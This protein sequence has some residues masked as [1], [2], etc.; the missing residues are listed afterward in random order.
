MD[1][2]D[3]PRPK[4]S[5]PGMSRGLAPGHVAFGHDR[6]IEVPFGH[7]CQDVFAGALAG[8]SELR[9]IR[10]DHGDFKPGESK[11]L[12]VDARE[13]DLDDRRGRL[14]EQVEDPRRRARSKRRWQPCHETY[15]GRMARKRTGRFL[16]VPYDWR[17]PTL[18]RVRS[19]WWNRNDRRVFTPKSFG[20]GW[21]V[22]FA[23]LTRRLRLRR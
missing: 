10:L 7:G 22:N 2:N 15:S 4:M 14:A 5:L 18:A 8:P 21:D 17:R 3:T 12:G 19:R 11:R 13:P 23:E 6:E 9:R 16:G 1:D 20:W